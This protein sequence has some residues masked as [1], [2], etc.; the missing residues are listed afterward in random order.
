MPFKII[1][2]NTQGFISVD[3]KNAFQ[4]LLL[5]FKPDC[6]CIQETNTNPKVHTLLKNN[7]YS[8]FYNPMNGAFSGT[9]VFVRNS[10]AVTANSVLMPSK[11]QVVTIKS[12]HETLNVFNIHMPHNDKLAL[13]LIEALDFHLSKYNSNEEI[14]LCGDWNY[15][16]NEL[17]DRIRSKERRKNVQIKMCTLLSKHSLVDSYRFLHPTRNEMTHSGSLSHKPLARL[18]RIYVRRNLC[19]SLCS[20]SIYP[21]PSDHAIVECTFNISKP[22]SNSVW[23]LNNSLINDE[24]FIYQINNLLKNF[25]INETK[26]PSDYE[27][28]KFEIQE[29]AIS[30]ENFNKINE[31]REKTKIQKF[32]QS[33][34][35][36]SSLAQKDLFESLVNNRNPIYENPSSLRK[37]PMN[38][39]SLNIDNVL[40]IKTNQEKIE[41]VQSFFKEKYKYRCV[42][43][44]GLNKYLKVLPQLSEDQKNDMSDIFTPQEY[45]KAI[46]LL[47][48]NKAPGSDG[49]SSEFYKKFSKFYVK[50][51]PWLLNKSTQF[52]LATLSENWNNQ[53]NL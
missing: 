31:K 5:S 14:F 20:C 18:D 6:V 24:N 30:T 46:Q 39:L 3:K 32:F 7:K 26:S 42:K 50:I 33:Q 10:L 19:K 53:S 48:N 44:R 25:V 13:E 49:L 1:T 12:Q 38:E 37:I 29:C 47:Q 17:T 2:I 35:L 15:V 8:Q 45:E 11:M 21:Y 41:H 27:I 52:H 43:Y 34:M 36:D 9:C 51:I 4:K 16:E 23:R 40:H 28:L 22:V